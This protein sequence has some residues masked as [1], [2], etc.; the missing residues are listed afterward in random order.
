MCNICPMDQ[1]AAD[2]CIT[3]VYMHS[4]I[5]MYHFFLKRCTCTCICWLLNVNKGPLGDLLAKTKAMKP[6]KQLQSQK[7]TQDRTMGPTM[8]TGRSGWT[9]CTTTVDGAPGTAL[10]C[11]WPPG[12]WPWGWAVYG[13]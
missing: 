8:L 11:T 3:S 12:Y 2:T 10:Y 5:R 13:C 7:T 6:N 4:V 1:R 9:V